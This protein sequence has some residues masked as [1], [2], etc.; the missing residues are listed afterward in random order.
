[1]LVDHITYGASW[2][3]YN[4]DGFLD[5]F[6]SSRNPSMGATPNLLFSNN[7]DNTFSVLDATS[8]FLE[9][10]YLSFC[11]A[12]FD[13]DKDGDQDVF[14]ANDKDPVNLFYENLGDENFLEIGA[15]NNTNLSMDA[16]STTIDDYN[17]DGWLD[18]Y[19]TNTFDGNAFFHNNGDGTFTNV[20]STNG[21]IM[22]SVGWGAVFFDADNNGF[23]DLYVSGEFGTDEDN[24][25]YAFYYNDGDGNFSSPQDIG[26]VSYTHLTLPTICSV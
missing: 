16:M 1:M 3:D 2:G 17:N 24:L 19:V 14:V 6:L 11:A 7:G 8:G 26:S 4:T 10:N 25:A 5:V 18:I 20:A 9:E 13:Y 21:T 23:K 22:E 12:I 15:A